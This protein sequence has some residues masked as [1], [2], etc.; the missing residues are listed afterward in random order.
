MWWYHFLG[1]D[2]LKGVSNIQNFL[3]WGY[4][5]FWAI[6]WYKGVIICPKMFWEVKLTWSK[7]S[8]VKIRKYLTG[9]AGPNFL[10]FLVVML[11]QLIWII[12]GKWWNWMKITPRPQNERFWKIWKSSKWK[13]LNIVFIGLSLIS[14][15]TS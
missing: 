9:T 7:A 5:E 8:N 2:T 10:E 15:V 3:K 11:G 12:S 1:Y 13:W 14:K 6:N 4:L